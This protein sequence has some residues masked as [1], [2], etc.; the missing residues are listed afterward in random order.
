MLNIETSVYVIVTSYSLQVSESGWPAVVCV[1]VDEE[2][3]VV[4][5]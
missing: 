1:V 5:S 4:E 3:D 2:A